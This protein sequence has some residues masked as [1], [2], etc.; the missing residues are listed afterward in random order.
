MF[1]SNTT[2]FIL[3]PLTSVLSEAVDALVVAQSG[4]YG[5]QIADWVMPTIF[6]RMTGAQEQ[7]LKCIC[8]DLGSIDLEG[9]NQ[10]Y[11]KKIGEMSCYDE[12]NYLC[13]DMIAFLLRNK[14]GFDPVADVD[15][16]TLLQE[17][18]NDVT[19]ICG[20]SIMREWYAD[21]Y[22]VFEEVYPS[23]IVDYFVVWKNN[24]KEKYRDL[25]IEDL[26][27]AYES[28]YFHRIRCAHN[29]TSFRSNLPKF[30]TLSSPKACYE[31]YFIRFFLLILLDEL[32]MQLYQAAITITEF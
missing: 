29:S 27:D 25:F 14:R 13:R 2:D 31:N 17:A 18:Y 5:Y 9:R 3:T 10:R 8:W 6:L 23:F 32:F 30:E 11:S 7:K 22:K 16:A 28:L 15:R 21:Y 20:N 26:K 19:A 4:M 24:L 12:K 1:R